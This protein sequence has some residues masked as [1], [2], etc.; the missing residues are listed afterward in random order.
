[1]GSQFVLYIQIFLV[2]KILFNSPFLFFAVCLPKMWF[3]RL[4]FKIDFW[5]FLERNLFSKNIQYTT[6]LFRQ[7]IG[8]AMKDIWWSY[9]TQKDWGQLAVYYTSPQ[10]F[11]I[12]FLF[13]EFRQF[14]LAILLS[15]LFKRLNHLSYSTQGVILCLIIEEC[16]LIYRP[17]SYPFRSLYATSTLTVGAV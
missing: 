14:L 5:L 15:C 6:F 13:C 7:S 11:I 12:T 17:L 8:H 3:S 10:G 4:L 1:M 9:A 16:T 2:A